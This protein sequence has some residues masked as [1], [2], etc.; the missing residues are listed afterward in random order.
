MR[1]EKMMNNT[2]L[3]LDRGELLRM[4]NALCANL[5]NFFE[6]DGH[7]IYFPPEEEKE[8]I[9]LS[10]ERKVLLPLWWQQ[11]FLG[12]LVLSGIKAR[13]MR[14]IISILPTL[15]TF[16]M[17]LE[18]MRLLHYRDSLTNL[19][20]EEFF[21]ANFENELA[22]LRD[23]RGDI[24]VSVQLGR[25]M[26]RLCRGLIVLRWNDA[27][28]A[29]HIHGPQFARDAFIALAARLS[30]ILPDST[31]AA[32]LGRFEN[33]GEFG[34]LVPAS[35]T[36]ACRNQAVRILESLQDFTWQSDVMG[37]PYSPGL[38]AG[39]ALYPHDIGGEENLL[40]I[41]E[42]VRRLRDRARLAARLAPSMDSF[43]RGARA[44]AYQDILVKAG[45]ILECRPDGTLRLNLGLT[46]NAGI[47]ARFDVYGYQESG[48]EV[49]KG[50]LVLTR[51]RE[52]DSFGE[53]LFYASADQPKSGD[54]LQPPKDNG[55]CANGPEIPG[56]IA[57]DDG[58]LNYR[59]FFAEFAAIATSFAL[60][61][62]QLRPAEGKEN[63]FEKNFENLLASLK[64]LTPTALIKGIY[65]NGGLLFCHVGEVPENL[66]DFYIS[67]T[68]L[69]SA[70]NLVAQAGI[71]CW[72]FLDYGKNEAQVCAQKALECAKL[73][74]DPQVAFFD[75]IAL[76]VN[77]DK[78][79]SVGNTLAAV[80]EYEAAVIA[81]S[82]NV[83]ALNSLGV[84][85][86]SLGKLDEARRYLS[87]ALR[88]CGEKGIAGQICYNLGA[89]Y[90]QEKNLSS[91]KNYYRRAVEHNPAH[92][93]AWL[94]LGQVCALSGRRAEAGRMFENAISKANGEEAIISA[95]RRQ[96]AKLRA[97]R[98]RSGSAREI[99][100]ENLL[101][102]PEDTGSI[103]ELAKL[104]LENSEDPAM[105]EMLALRGVKMG[106]GR[107]AR[108]ILAQALEKQGKM[109]E[110]L[111]VRQT[112]V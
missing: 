101:A 84:A 70:N 12:V 61:E 97:K 18:V 112:G 60:A 19:A 2:L 87:R 28:E 41:F 52:H 7:A 63:D 83:T 6:F 14:A 68:V 9:L 22:A 10:Q 57:L 59:A 78:L 5:A 4:E 73:L 54:R 100:H 75:S 38:Y 93:W 105:A 103:L 55:L 49:R 47:G 8:V 26:H 95:A 29:L 71:F 37:I 65:G 82:K 109:E 92:A 42:Q 20:S 45:R 56:N 62:V 30:Q 94:R 80:R 46:A 31:V 99:L 77:A 25:Q 53:M 111:R 17:G 106:G 69:A 3:N 44:L 34:I 107:V 58:W 33:S 67:L 1:F 39:F 23:L 24:P 89:I 79:Y 48:Q 104:Y 74:P 51:V 102:H 90:Q 86:A 32:P 66:R 91:A 81:D 16:C 85:I 96:I 43:A 98:D 35:G 110:A 72:P 36:V 15:A 64:E 76:T 40:P 108:D 13:K 21:Y 88:I 50:Q 27:E 11:D